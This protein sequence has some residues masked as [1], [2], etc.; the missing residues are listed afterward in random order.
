MQEPDPRSGPAVVVVG[1][2]PKATGMPPSDLRTISPT[3]SESEAMS[4]TLKNV[5][6]EPEASVEALLMD[7]EVPNKEG[8]MKPV[9]SSDS[10]MALAAQSSF[11]GLGTGASGAANGTL[12]YPTIPPP[13]MMAAPQL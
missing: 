8:Q 7:P 1:S 3:P 2:P 12:A 9:Y 4:P 5:K 10:L 13:S 11:S 6:R